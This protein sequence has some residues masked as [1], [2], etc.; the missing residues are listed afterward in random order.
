MV[1][2][3]FWYFTLQPT[4]HTVSFETNSPLRV[5]GF[6]EHGETESVKGGLYL[7][8]NICITKN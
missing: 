5:G 6:A 7:K 4:Q 8:N 3:L 2:N 1:D